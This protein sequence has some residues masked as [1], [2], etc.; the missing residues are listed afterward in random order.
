MHQNALSRIS[1]E[2][3]ATSV[4]CGVERCVA[5]PRLGSRSTNQ[6]IAPSRM[7]GAPASRNAQR[8]L[9]TDSSSP[10]IASPV[11]APSGVPS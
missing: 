1:V 6:T 11:S 2:I 3:A 10:P 9:S 4:T 7:P 5:I 8:Q